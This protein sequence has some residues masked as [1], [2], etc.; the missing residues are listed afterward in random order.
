LRP[1]MGRLPMARDHTRSSDTPVFV[2][3]YTHLEGPF[4]ELASVF[5]ARDFPLNDWATDAY[6][7]GESL[8]ARIGMGGSEAPL[9]AKTVELHLEDRH[10]S[11]DRVV[12][13]MSW[14]A[15]GPTALFPRMDADLIIEPLGPDLTQLS[16]QGSYVP[17]L[18]VAGMLLDRWVLHRVAEASVK[19]LVDRVA[20]ALRTHESVDTE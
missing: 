11:A 8:T 12:L 18:G 19:N 1:A 14:T 2:K 15:T 20:K 10:A 5:S 13:S 16:F 3:Y 9:V 17:P 7:D 6:R 4:S